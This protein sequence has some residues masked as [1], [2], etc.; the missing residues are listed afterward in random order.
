MKPN[1]KNNHQSSTHS[2]HSP[3]DSPASSLD[4]HKLW[5]KYSIRSNEEWS[6]STLAASKVLS[7]GYFDGSCYYSGLTVVTFFTMMTDLRIVQNK[8]LSKQCI[9][10]ECQMLSGLRIPAT[11][12]FTGL[13]SLRNNWTISMAARKSPCFLCSS[14]VLEYLDRG[15]SHLSSSEP[16]IH[17]WCTKA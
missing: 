17:Y 5:Y 12:H 14:L 16:H 3:R 4:L 11:K 10:G 2:S 6:L 8:S 7:Y 13:T 15:P 1:P 9:V